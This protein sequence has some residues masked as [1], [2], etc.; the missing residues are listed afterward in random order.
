[1]IDLGIG[2]K[3]DQTIFKKMKS[4]FGGSEQYESLPILNLAGREMDKAYNQLKVLDMIAP[5][6]RGNTDDGRE[7]FAIRFLNSHNNFSCLVI[8]QYTVTDYNTW[9]RGGDGGLID[10]GT[11]I[12]EGKTVVLT[13]NSIPFDD[14]AEVIKSGAN[15]EYTIQ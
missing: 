7:F 1:M 12:D 14:L 15:G 2:L 13:D 11:I 10:V 8:S 6:M 5:I 3:E 4:L 9:M